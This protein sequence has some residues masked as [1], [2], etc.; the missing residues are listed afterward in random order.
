MTER[1]ELIVIGGRSG[2]GKTSVAMEMHYLLSKC[3]I[4]HAVIEG[5]NLDQ[6]WPPPWEHEL[7]EQNLAAMWANYRSLGYR[8]LI[9]TNT[10]SIL[11]ADRLA[12]AMGDAP[13][14]H[15]ILLTASDETAKARLAQREIGEALDIHLVR[16]SDRAR[17]LDANAGLG[18]HRIPTDGRS[19]T[20][21][22]NDI[23]E[24]AGWTQPSDVQEM[25]PIT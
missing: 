16:S 10:V 21:I 6:A 18:V 1:S 14:V 8:R 9:Y 2:V 5:D 15:S 17:D 3:G 25:E 12:D 13:L 11:M 20:N 22:A 19:I 7:D 24:L 4:R 23:I